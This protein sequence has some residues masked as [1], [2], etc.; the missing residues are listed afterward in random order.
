[1]LPRDGSGLPAW[2]RAVMPWVMAAVRAVALWLVLRGPAAFLW[3]P[4]FPS[5]VPTPLR[6]A[7]LLLLILATPLFV[8]SRTCWVGAAIAALGLGGYEWL[9][10]RTGL[11]HGDVP[12]A[13]FIMVA[14]LAIGETVSRRVRRDLYR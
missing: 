2:R 6:W 9:W 3:Q 13:S 8:V 14:V 4:P 12:F 1:M 7:I 10:S 11:P 5:L